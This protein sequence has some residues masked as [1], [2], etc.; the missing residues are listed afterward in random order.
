MFA[1]L[2]DILF[3]FTQPDYHIFEHFLHEYPFLRVRHLVEGVF[4]LP[5]DLEIAKVEGSVVLEPLIV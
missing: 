4:E 5:I 1:E 3:D 2:D